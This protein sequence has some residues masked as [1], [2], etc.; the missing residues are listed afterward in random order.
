VLS[1]SRQEEGLVQ[2]WERLRQWLALVRAMIP[3]R[4]LQQLGMGGL[5]KQVRGCVSPLARH[6]MRLLRLRT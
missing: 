2:L 3:E 1:H 4:E 6:A 5:D